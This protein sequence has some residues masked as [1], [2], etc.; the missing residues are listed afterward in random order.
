MDAG[1]FAEVRAEARGICAEL[2]DRACVAAAYR[3]EANAWATTGSPAKARPMYAAALKMANEMGNLLEKLNALNGL[4]YVEQLQGDLEAAERDF[5]EALAVGTEIGAQKRYPVCL[6][7]AEVLA[8]RGREADAR[9]FAKEALDA[10]TLA[11][12]PESSG[13][14]EAV[15]GRSLALEGK[16]ADAIARYNAAVGALRDVNEPVELGR[17]LLELGDAQLQQ[18]DEAGARKSYEEVRELDRRHRGFAHPEMEVAFARLALHDGKAE[19]AATLARSALNE[20]TAAERKGDRMQAAAVLVRALIARGKVAEASETVSQIAPGDGKSL[21]VEASV[22][23]RIA[24]CLVAA[25]TG[26]RADADREMETISGEVSRIGLAPL[27]KET[28][29][30]REALLRV[31]SASPPL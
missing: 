27:E 31:A 14:S 12:D 3:I 28:R 17:A 1:G 18:G 4:G 8:E 21:P 2:G 15:L 5:R 11:H 19:E 16:L 26:H 29:Q 13:L 23:F 7:L 24:R 6:D 10:A 20:F 22:R 25:N 30:A 9:V